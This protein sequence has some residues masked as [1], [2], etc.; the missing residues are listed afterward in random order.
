MNTFNISRKTTRPIIDF[1]QLTLKWQ[2]KFDYC[3]GQGSFFSYRGEFYDLGEFVSLGEGFANSNEKN[4]KL[5]G[6]HGVQSDSYFSGILVCI[7]EGNSDE[8]KVAHYTS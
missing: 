6:F 8:I 5:K 7:D 2:S 3:K 1:D 4:E